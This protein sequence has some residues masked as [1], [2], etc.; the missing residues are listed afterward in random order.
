MIVRCW[1]SLFVNLGSLIFTALQFGNLAR[2]FD[3]HGSPIVV[4]LPAKKRLGFGLKL[5]DAH[6]S[7]LFVQS[8]MTTLGRA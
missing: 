3:H 4:L 5:T 1:F 8:A 7:G 6:R 2:V